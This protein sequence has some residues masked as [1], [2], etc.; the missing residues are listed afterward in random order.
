M[1]NILYKVSFPAEFHAQTAA[2]A[3]I[4]LSEVKGKIHDIKEIKIFTQNQV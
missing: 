2:E 4:S 1:D 3:S